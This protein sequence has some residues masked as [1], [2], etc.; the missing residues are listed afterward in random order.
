MAFNTRNP[1]GST[2]PR[3]LYDNAANFDKLANGIDPFYTD[4][5]GKLRHSFAGMEEDFNNAQDGRQEAFEY[6]EKQRN[7][8][9]YSGENQRNTAFKLS[10]QSQEDRFQAFLES[11]GYQDL[12]IYK[13][14]IVLDALNKTFSYN[15]FYYH[16]K[17]GV[18][19]PYTTTGVWADESE[20]F[21]L[22]GD[23]ILRQDIASTSGNKGAYITGYRSRTVGARLDDSP[24]AKDFTSAQ[25]VD[26]IV[27]HDDLLMLPDGSPSFDL[28]ST[29][30]SVL[31]YVGPAVQML[32]PWGG[33]TVSTNEVVR[34][35]IRGQTPA[36]HQNI[37]H[38]LFGLEMEALGSGYNGPTNADIGQKIYIRKKGF[39]EGSSAA[40]EID[41][42]QIVVRQG[43]RLSDCSGI[44]A[45]V[46][47]Y[48]TGYSAVLEGLT[49]LVENN[50]LTKQVQTQAAII[51][52]VA[53]A[54][55]GHQVA[56][57]YGSCDDAYVAT[58]G[59]AS[60]N[61]GTWKNFFRG[62]TNGVSRLLI[63]AKGR[64]TMADDTGASKS[65]D[66]QSNKF[67]I[68]NSAQNSEILTVDDAGAVSCN[69]VS[70]NGYVATGVAPPNASGISYG[71]TVASTATSGAS[72]VLPSQVAGYIIARVN[73]VLVKIPYF[74]N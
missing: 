51:D 9:F 61:N 31:D 2:D 29:Y 1:V 14:G 48:G 33:R 55:V 52:T 38:G 60:G 67:R 59:V 19:L 49:G 58:Q 27:K 73:N 12:G 16:L 63:T 10:Q 25:L 62:I 65:L 4:R 42:L 36:N 7:T 23:D 17:G 45:N 26:H 68:L 20:N 11:S 41:G 39:T 54:I 40:G 24:S 32:V 74:N 35:L 3:D 71:G 46:V 69:T 66:V 70:G 30:Y 18:A 13:A 56:A 57:V 34:R 28:P 72:G 8:A 22:L 64:I 50:V 5:L 15:G 53:D 47:H 43:G 37:C 6:G 21:V 44:L